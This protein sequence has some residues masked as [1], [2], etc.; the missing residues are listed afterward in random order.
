VLDLGS[1]VEKGEVVADFSPNPRAYAPGRD[2]SLAKIFA[3]G[4][5]KGAAKAG[6]ALRS[7]NG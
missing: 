3:G 5:G 6:E 4:C 1:A 2:S 7:G